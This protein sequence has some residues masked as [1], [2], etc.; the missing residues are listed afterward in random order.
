MVNPKTLNRPPTPALERRGSP[1]FTSARLNT[2]ASGR[3]SL[4]PLMP[5]GVSAK[6]RGRFRVR[7][8]HFFASAFFS[9][10]SRFLPLRICIP[11]QDQSALE[12]TSRLRISFRRGASPLPAS[13]ISSRREGELE[14]SGSRFESRR[15]SGELVCRR[16]SLAEPRSVPVQ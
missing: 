6:R 14:P 13:P 12:P 16:T 10:I 2:F 11:F 7:N 1:E 15:S 9:R 3:F 4:I 8:S 5:G